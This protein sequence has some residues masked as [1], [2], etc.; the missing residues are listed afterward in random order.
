MSHHDNT[1]RH[2]LPPGPE[3]ELSVTVTHH[4]AG[5]TQVFIVGEIDLAT[6]RE[7]RDTLGGQPEQ[8]VTA[9]IVDL[10]RVSFCSVRGMRLL[11]GLQDRAGQAGV[12]VEVV[13]GGHAV[14]RCMCAC[15]VRDL[16]S[17]HRD[18]TTALAALGAGGVPRR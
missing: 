12:P 16:F 18:H 6:V 14:R 8:D 3:A 7:W 17:V 13:D 10:S 1:P 4:H 5:I 11:C 15:G 2:R 9:L